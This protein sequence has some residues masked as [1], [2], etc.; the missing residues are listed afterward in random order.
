MT[1][2]TR[3]WKNAARKTIINTM[4]RICFFILAGTLLSI[5]ACNNA[6]KESSPAVV[7][8]LAD[9]LENEV[10]EGHNTG[11]LKMAPLTRAQQE[12]TRLLDSIGKLPARAQQAAA[13][14]KAR[15][16][17][18]LRDLNYA[19]VSMNKWMSEYKWDSAFTGPKEKI[20]YLQSEK[21]KVSKVKEAI[22]GS[23]QKADSVLR[24][25]F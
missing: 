13:P 18:L 6:G 22:L 3:S 25:K 9:T 15:L 10:N 7:R 4:K 20:S 1:S 11:M 12:A 2:S 19:D 8:T 17:N 14:Y 16:E 24:R 23:L 5:A 21:E